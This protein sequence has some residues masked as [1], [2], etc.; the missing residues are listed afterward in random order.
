M[1]PLNFEWK[2]SLRF[3]KPI[4][5]ITNLLSSNPECIFAGHINLLDKYTVFA[6]GENMLQPNYTMYA[7]MIGPKQY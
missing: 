2:C 6:K 7:T 5:L 3:S 1:Q 4:S